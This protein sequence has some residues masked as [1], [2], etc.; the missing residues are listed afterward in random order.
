MIITNLVT[1]VMRL[2][3]SKTFDKIWHDSVIFKMEQNSIS[4]KLHKL[5]HDFLIN[6]KQEVILNGQVFSWAYFKAGVPQVSIS[7]LGLSLFL[8]YINNLP[9]GLSTNTKLFP[10]N[11]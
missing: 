2:E 4:G 11:T 7:I 8:I 5:L 6:R 10:E 3:V 9:K 1:A